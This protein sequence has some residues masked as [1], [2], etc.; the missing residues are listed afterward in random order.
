MRTRTMETEV[1]PLTPAEVRQRSQNAIPPA[2]I[3][4]VN[5]L[6]VADGHS[7]A[8]IVKREPLIALILKKHWPDAPEDTLPTFRREILDRGWLDFE[9]LFEKQGWNVQYNAPDRGDSNNYD[10]Y[11]R[12]T[13]KRRG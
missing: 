3:E 4:A 5:E 7:S 10:P 11:F 13:P 2:V 8:P 9:P 12:F 1:K 6:I